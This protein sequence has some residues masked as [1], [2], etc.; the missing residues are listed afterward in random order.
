MFPVGP[1]SDL[2]GGAELVFSPLFQKEILRI[3]FAESGSINMAVAH[4]SDERSWWKALEGDIS[5]K[6]INCK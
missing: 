5:A 4:M 2:L 6:G 1:F 3:H